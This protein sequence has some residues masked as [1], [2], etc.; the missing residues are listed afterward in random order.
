MSE[1]VGYKGRLVPVEVNGYEDIEETC[2]R[3][4]EENGIEK[5]E[6]STTYV[7]DI[8]EN[9]DEYIVIDD[10]LYQK[11][12]VEKFDPSYYNSIVE[13]DDGSIDFISIFYNGGTY[14]NEMLEDGVSS[15]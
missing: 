12:D 3:I 4:Y 7:E 8:R 6:Y 10:I 9:S 15:I 5:S 11:E 1:T 2:K 14:L 13:N